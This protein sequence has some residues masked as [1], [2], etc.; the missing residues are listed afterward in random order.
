[1]LINKEADRTISLL[2]IKLNHHLGFKMTVG[3]TYAQNEKKM[4]I[5]TQR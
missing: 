2:H 1:V 5:R 4:K 3:T